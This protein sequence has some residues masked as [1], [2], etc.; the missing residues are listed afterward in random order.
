MSR[1]YKLSKRVQKVLSERKHIDEG[2]NLSVLDG[3]TD[4]PPDDFTTVQWISKLVIQ[5]DGSQQRIGDEITPSSLV[6]RYNFFYPA[7]THGFDATD[8]SVNVRLIVF[9]WFPLITTTTLPHI[10]EILDFSQQSGTGDL[11]PQLRVLAGYNRDFA[12]QYKIL[13][14]KII[15]LRLNTFAVN[16]PSTDNYKTTNLGGDEPREVT[17][18][19]MRP[20]EYTLDNGEAGTN[21]ILFLVIGDSSVAPNPTFN[22]VV[23]L[24]YYDS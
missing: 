14:D 20:I 16:I 22:A 13:Y 23:R 19:K 11:I 10:A 24:S 21:Q 8:T 1:I 17:I 4:E 5:G 2:Y 18:F 7:T 6:I 12:S 3:G 9:Q 15:P